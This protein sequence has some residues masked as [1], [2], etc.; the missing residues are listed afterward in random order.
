MKLAI[1]LYEEMT[2]LDAVGP[3][4]ALCHLPEAEVALV[5]KEAGPIHAE[6][7]PLQL[8]ADASLSE[9]GDPDVLLVPGGRGTFALRDDAEVLDWLREVDRGTTWTTSVCSGSMVLGYAGLLDGKRATTHWA[10]LDSLAELGAEPVSERVVEDGKLITAAGVSSGIDMAL[11]LAERLAGRD[12][13]EAIQLGI[14]YDPDP[15]FDSGSPRTARPELVELV[16]TVMAGQG[17]A[18]ERE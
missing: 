1:L 6:G 3:Y 2:A 5:A 8:V 13:A 17:M 16:R 14:E 11:T 4:E 10:W 15:P 12:M 9:V 7:G 18:P